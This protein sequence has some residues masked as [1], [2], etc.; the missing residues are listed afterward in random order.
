MA[1]RILFIDRDGTL[2]NETQPTYQIDSWQ[3]L[4]FYPHV[5]K[6]M[7]LIAAEF[8]YELVM[9]SNQDGLGTAAYPEEIFWPI[10]NFVIKSLEHEGIHFSACHFDKTFPADNAPT[11]KPNTGMLTSYLNNAAYD[12]AT[13]FVIGDRITDMQ[14][15]KNLGCKGIWLNNDFSLGAAE[16]SDKITELR[17][18]TI[19]C[20]TQY[21]KGIYLALKKINSNQSP[22]N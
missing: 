12:I 10:Q 2:I 6:Y 13:S 5:F 22:I 14:L 19:V 20:E 7:S 17:I 11:R 3:K 15:A 9:V 18:S 4:E 1:K 16:I 8:D 21:W